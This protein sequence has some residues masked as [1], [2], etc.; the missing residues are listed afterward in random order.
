MSNHPNYL[1]TPW[2]GKL[3]SSLMSLFFSPNIYR[4]LSSTELLEILGREF[5]GKFKSEYVTYFWRLSMATFWLKNQLWSPQC[6]SFCSNPF[7]KSP[8][9]CSHTHSKLQ[10]WRTILSFWNSLCSPDI[11]IL[12]LLL[13]YVLYQTHVN[14]KDLMLRGQ[15]PQVTTC[16]EFPGRGPKPEAGRLT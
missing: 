9:Q 15:L 2:V 11:F 12:L 10:S 3:G 14:E 7:F 8:I 16:T 1:P 5:Y 4:S 6:P 13:R